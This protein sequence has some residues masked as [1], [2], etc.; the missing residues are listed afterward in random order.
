M[1]NLLSFTQAK[2]KEE[3]LALGESSYRSKQVFSWI[4]QKHVYDFDQMSDVSKSFRAKLKEENSPAKTQG[5]A[6]SSC[7]WRW[8]TEPRWKPF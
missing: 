5:T 8:K 2:M 7:F 4:Y 3:F 6:P 1:K